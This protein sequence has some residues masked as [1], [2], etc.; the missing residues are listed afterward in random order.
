[1][2]QVF[3]ADTNDNK[4]VGFLDKSKTI[5]VVVQ[6]VS[7]HGAFLLPPVAYV[8]RAQP[9]GAAAHTS[10][11][12][13][14]KQARSNSTDALERGGVRRRHVFPAEDDGGGEKHDAATAAAE[15]AEQKSFSS[16]CFSITKNSET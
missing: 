3:I 12:Q 15:K 4:L 5:T 1:M 2:I 7:S 6:Q 8:T 11:P 13:C 14:F 16:L 10:T 9:D